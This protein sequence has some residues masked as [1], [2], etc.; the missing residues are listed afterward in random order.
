MRLLWPAADEDG[1]LEQSASRDEHADFERYCTYL[2]QRSGPRLFGLLA[3]VVLVTWPVDVLLA[4]PTGHTASLAALR[5]SVLIFLGG[6]AMVLP[7]LPAF[8]RL[9]EWHLAALAV[10]AAV[11]AAWFAS[12]L[13]GFDSPVFHVLSLVP[14]LVV[15]FPGSLRFRVALTTALAVVVWVVFALRPD[16]PV[17]RQGAAALQLGLVTLY[18]VAL[19]QLVFMLTRTNFLVR[20]R[21]GVQE[22]WLRELNENLEAHVADKAL[23]LRRLAR[24]LETTREDERKWIAREI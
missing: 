15:L 21:L 12:A 8:E 22:Q 14:L 20:H 24:H 18:S 3:A 19:G 5:V 7:R 23:E 10:P 2:L 6:G 16:G 17:L 9:P 13:G 4:G 11:L 1:V